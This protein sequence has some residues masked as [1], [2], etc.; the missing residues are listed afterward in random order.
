MFQPCTSFNPRRIPKGPF[1]GRSSSFEILRLGILRFCG[2]ARRRR[3]L[4]SVFFEKCSIVYHCDPIRLAQLGCADA[5]EAS[6]ALS[7]R[8]QS[9]L[10]RG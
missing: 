3:S 1:G 6:G 9:S 4:S 8:H 10:C 2:F 7:P 5:A